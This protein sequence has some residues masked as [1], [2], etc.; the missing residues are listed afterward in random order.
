[1]QNKLYIAMLVHNMQILI[2]IVILTNWGWFSVFTPHIHTFGLTYTIFGFTYIH[3]FTHIT[4]KNPYSQLSRLCLSTSQCY[5]ECNGNI[6]WV[7]SDTSY[8]ET[9]QTISAM[10]FFKYFTNLIVCFILCVVFVWQLDNVLIQTDGQI[11][12][13]NTFSICE[14]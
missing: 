10:H 11:F 9:N 8:L 3:M 4:C 6:H 12:V 2:G 1:M 14:E 5:Y 7:E 13:R